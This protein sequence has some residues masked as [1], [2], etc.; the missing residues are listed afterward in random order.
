MFLQNKRNRY[1]CVRKL[2][3]HLLTVHRRA[4][5]ERKYETITYSCVRFAKA[6]DAEVT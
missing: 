1:K 6:I 5:F 2:N 3:M 4:F